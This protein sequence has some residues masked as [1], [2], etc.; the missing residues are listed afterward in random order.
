[1]LITIQVIIIIII[2]II[3]EKGQQCKAGR[4]W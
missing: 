3:I 2:I 1:M 4:E